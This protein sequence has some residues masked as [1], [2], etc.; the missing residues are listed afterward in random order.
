MNKSF[1]EAQ[2]GSLWYLVWVPFA[3]IVFA[4]TRKR[5]LKHTTQTQWS[6]CVTKRERERDGNSLP[7]LAI[8][9]D[10]LRRWRRTCRVCRSDVSAAADV[11][12]SCSVS[13]CDIV[14][15]F[16]GRGVDI[17]S[18][19]L[20]LLLFIYWNVFLK[21]FCNLFGLLF[22]GFTIALLILLN[23]FSALLFL[24]LYS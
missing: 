5:Y 14:L 12:C 3:E 2:T 18:G 21:I 20:L 9:C 10:M 13:L 7:M 23:E 22:F 16:I 24:F 6:N 19:L 11:V 1:K 8:S 15:F 17:L 4:D